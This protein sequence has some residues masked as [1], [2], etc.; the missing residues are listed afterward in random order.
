MSFS[1]SL[2][3]R[4]ISPAIFLAVFCHLKSNLNFFKGQRIFWSSFSEAPI[5]GPYSWFLVYF[6]DFFV[7]L[8]DFLSKTR[9]KNL[10][11]KSQLTQKPN[12]LGHSPRRADQFCYS[13]LISEMCIFRVI[14]KK[15]IFLKVVEYSKIKMSP[16]WIKI[17]WFIDR[18]M[19]ITNWWATMGPWCFFGPLGGFKVD[20]WGSAPL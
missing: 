16:N 19:L 20:F 17:G 4:N 1:G 6:C 14:A 3:W 15:R 13:W 18:D 8:A 2:G 9:S 11:K 12:T 5:I 7:I 10:K